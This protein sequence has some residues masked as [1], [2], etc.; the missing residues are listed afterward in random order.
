LPSELVTGGPIAIALDESL[1]ELATLAIR[2]GPRAQEL[3][4]GVVLDIGLFDR[5]DA[6][7]MSAFEH[8]TFRGSG[9]H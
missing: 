6:N 8:G 9:G 4:E 5:S 7:A 3:A 1:P 2:L